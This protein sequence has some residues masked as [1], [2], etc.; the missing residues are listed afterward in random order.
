MTRVE[1]I[2]WLVI[3]G[4]PIGLI[5]Y[6]AL[7]LRREARPDPMASA[8]GDVPHVHHAETWR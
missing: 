8:H 3:F 6:V 5:G 4:G 2:F 7:H 1:L